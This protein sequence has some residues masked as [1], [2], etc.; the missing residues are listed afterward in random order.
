MPAK[1]KYHMNNLKAIVEQAMREY[2]GE[3]LN[4]VTTFTQSDD[5]TIMCI[6]F[7]GKIRDRHF[8]T[9]SIM[10]RI[11][12]EQV[13]IED[14]KT[15]KPLSDALIQA[16]VPREQIILVYEGEPIHEIA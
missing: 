5:Q 10:V 14:D 3:G 13:I 4:G 15:N 7:V 12:G 6:I 11:V 2:A 16:G 8:A 1:D 9:T